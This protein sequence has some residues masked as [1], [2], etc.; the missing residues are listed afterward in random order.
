M[1]T[2]PDGRNPVILIGGG[3]SLLGSGAVVNQIN[4]NP[5]ET[6]EFY[7][8]C[9]KAIYTVHNALNYGILFSKKPPKG[10]KKAVDQHT[11]KPRKVPEGT[12]DIDQI[13]PNDN[14][15]LYKAFVLKPEAS[16]I[17][18]DKDT[19]IFFTWV[20]EIDSIIVTYLKDEVFY[21]E[22]DA[23]T[24]T[25]EDY[26]ELLALY[27]RYKIPKTQLLSLKNSV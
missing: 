26:E 8:Q 4:N 2:D 12:M 20:N 9:V 14:N 3:L 27:E 16:L 7:N 6:D 5:Q 11:K 25:A 17:R 22:V 10:S 21:M 15:K 23:R 13:K 1:Y 24:L 19:D 18:S